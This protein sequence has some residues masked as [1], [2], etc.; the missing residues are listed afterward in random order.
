MVKL[1]FPICNKVVFSLLPYFAVAFQRKLG[2]KHCLPLDFQKCIIA[3][4][5]S[6]KHLHVILKTVKKYL[7]HLELD[8]EIQI[9]EISTQSGIVN[10]W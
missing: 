8:Q 1:V 4:R 2:V 10:G 7:S 5:F 3:K 6:K 9:K